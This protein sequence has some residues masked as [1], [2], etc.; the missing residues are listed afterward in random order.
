MALN[1]SKCNCLTPLHFKGLK[2]KQAI[3]L[4]CLQSHNSATTETLITVTLRSS[5]C[6]FMKTTYSIKMYLC[7]TWILAFYLVQLIESHPL[8]C[9]VKCIDNFAPISLSP[10][11]T[12]LTCLPSSSS[13]PFH[14]L[15]SGCEIILFITTREVKSSSW[16]RPHDYWPRPH[17]SCGLGFVQLGL[18]AS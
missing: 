9:L 3:T 1:T 10:R 7:G 6:G 15:F 5:C 18:M 8:T 2:H 11:G 13:I 16:P 12:P 4:L 14:C 17:D